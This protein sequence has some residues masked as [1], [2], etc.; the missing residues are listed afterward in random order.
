LIAIGGGAFAK[1][2]GVIYSHIDSN[3]ATSDL[4]YG[5]LGGGLMTQQPYLYTSTIS[6]NAVVIHAG[7][8]T[9]GTGNVGAGGGLIAEN[10]GTLQSSTISGNRMTCTSANLTSYNTACV[11]AGVVNSYSGSGGSGYPFAVYDSTISGNATT[12]SSGGALCLAGGMDSKYEMNIAQSTI[13]GN[14]AQIGAALM[15]KYAGKG[16][17]S[18]Y[19]TTIA[20][21][22]AADTGG[23]IY[24]Y[25][26][27]RIAPTS[28]PPAP[29]TL[30]SSIVANN[31]TAGAPDDIYL[32]DTQS[33]TISG[34]SNLVMAASP[35]ITLPGG[36]LGADP[37]LGS[38]ANNG[39]PTLTMGL[40]AGSPALGVGINPNGYTNDQRGTGFPRT[41][42]GLTD[43]GAFQGTVAAPAAKIPAPTLSTWGLGLLAGLL[44]L[45]GWRRRHT[46]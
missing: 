7:S 16:G 28:T 5:A 45:F 39:G 11:G 17:V 19:N 14:S 18:I 20:A 43:I 38:L 42:G 22:S 27:G 34:A 33:L 30:V 40:L 25:T 12:C 37:L 6:R 31:S 15:L 9:G 24:E 44:G 36:T 32:S 41:V 29:I 46:A 1:Y 4:G 10:G 8:S 3:T 23:G 2:A 26:G 13:S 35:S 21:N